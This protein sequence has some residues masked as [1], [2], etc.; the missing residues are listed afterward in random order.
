MGLVVKTFLFSFAEYEDFYLVIHNIDGTMLRGEKIQMILS[1]L[2]AIRGFHI[3]AS[4]DHINAPLSEY[5]S[6]H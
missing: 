1:L 3:I 5:H 6:C 2:A 4:I